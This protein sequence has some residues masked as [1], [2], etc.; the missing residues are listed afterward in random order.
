MV[1]GSANLKGGTTNIATNDGDVTTWVY[2]GTYWYLMNF[3]DQ[4]ADL[5]GGH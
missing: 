2:D 4:S 1:S 3:M 5:S